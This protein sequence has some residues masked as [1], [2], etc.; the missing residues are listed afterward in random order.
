M[1]GKLLAGLLARRSNGSVGNT[2][3]DVFGIMAVAKLTGA[4]GTDKPDVTLKV[5]GKAIEARLVHDVAGSGKRALLSGP[6]VGKA[7]QLV[8][9]F[10]NGGKPVHA[11]VR[12]EYVAEL[13]AHNRAPR[14]AG[15]A[16]NPAVRDHRRRLPRWA[17]T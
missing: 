8:V 11:T 13:D 14:S 9:E 3:E 15:F 12:V 16:I 10:A 2:Q 17:S 7:D 1:S 6:D 4:P 5:D